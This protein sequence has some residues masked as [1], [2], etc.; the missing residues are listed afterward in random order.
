MVVQVAYGQAG[1][2][3]AGRSVSGLNQLVFHGFGVM[4]V[5]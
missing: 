5:V 3:G 4:T 2:V 1:I